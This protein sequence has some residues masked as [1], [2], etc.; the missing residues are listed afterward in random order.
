MLPERRKAAPLGPMR[1]R[2]FGNRL[3][4]RIFT[5]DIQKRRR[6]IRSGQVSHPTKPFFVPGQNWE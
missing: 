3:P 1:D 2:V 5:V 6:R 4:A